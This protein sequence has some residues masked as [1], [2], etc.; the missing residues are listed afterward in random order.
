MA[1]N[2]NHEFEDLNGIKCAIVQK[3]ATAERV[4]FLKELLNYNGYTVVVI[5]TPVA[6]A[7]AVAAVA[8]GAAAPAATEAAPP[9]ATFTVGVT[10]LV[11]NPTNAI[12]GRLLKTPDGHTVTL[13]YW[14]Q[15]EAVANDEVPYYEKVVS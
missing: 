3:N 5:A 12:F 2:K 8:G 4:A 11:F 10:D 13:S 14:H 7:K 1:I 15:K 6:P 9:P